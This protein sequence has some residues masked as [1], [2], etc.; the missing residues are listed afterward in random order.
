MGVV[1]LS[2]SRL[3]IRAKMASF[4]LSAMGSYLL[5]AITDPVLHHCGI[6]RS[7]WKHHFRKR[8]RIF[9]ALYFLI[10]QKS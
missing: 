9:V 5:G 2:A 6:P 4:R 3:C 7:Q 8:V 1:S 10:G